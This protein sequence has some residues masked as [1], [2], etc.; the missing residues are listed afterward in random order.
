M[1]VI[2]MSQLE[3][4]TL[5]ASRLDVSSFQMKFKEPVLIFPARSEV[6]VLK[7]SRTTLGR[8]PRNDVCLPLTTVSKVHATLE[9]AGKNV[10]L[11]D[12]GSTNGT[13][14]D[15]ARVAPNEA[16]PL[17]SGAQIR[18]GDEAQAMFLTPE[19]FYGYLMLRFMGEES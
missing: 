13:F 6:F 16:H 1:G 7:K 2:A 9:V 17:P 3:D 15:G 12:L 4:L 5:A 10:T 14:V 19:G 18:F 11:E 8:D